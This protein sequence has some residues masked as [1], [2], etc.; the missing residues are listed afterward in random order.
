MGDKG[1]SDLSRAAMRFCSARPGCSSWPL[2]A[3]Y[4]TL[5]LSISTSAPDLEVAVLF[6]AIITI[7]SD[8][9]DNRLLREVC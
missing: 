2:P 3:M 6:I 5:I 4:P 1:N 7:P 9:L 8:R